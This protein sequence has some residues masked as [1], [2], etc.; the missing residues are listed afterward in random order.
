MEA[1]GE[2]Y[3][4]LKEGFDSESVR[5]SLID[6]RDRLWL[7]WHAVVAALRYKASFADILRAVALAY[8][9]PAVIINGRLVFA[10]E[11]PQPEAVD[12]AVRAHLGKVA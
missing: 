8:T 2:I 7:W 6:P 11:I 3:R 1:M 9:F 12:E 4:R 5:V 10:G